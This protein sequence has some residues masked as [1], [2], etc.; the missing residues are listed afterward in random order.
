M[1]SGTVCQTALSPAAPSRFILQKKPH[2][3]ALGCD[4]IVTREVMEDLIVIVK[5]LHD[6][7]QFPLTPIEFVDSELSTVFMNSKRA[8]TDFHNYPLKLRQAISLA[9]RLQDPLLEFSQLCSADEEILCLK[10]HP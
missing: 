3:I 1:C 10:Y 2:V 9:R 5:E 8:N 7:E 4:S 6:S